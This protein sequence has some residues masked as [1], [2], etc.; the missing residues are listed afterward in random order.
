MVKAMAEIT[1]IAG[2][3]VTAAVIALKQVLQKNKKRWI[4]LDYT[5]RL[6]LVLQ[7]MTENNLN[8]DVATWIDLANLR[9]WAGYC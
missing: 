5:G 4:V 8:S 2:C 1:V 3:G 9:N 7:G 6:S